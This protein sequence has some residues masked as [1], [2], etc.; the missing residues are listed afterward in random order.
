MNM[1]TKENSA[2]RQK[3]MQQLDHVFAD[4]A[5]NNTNCLV[6]DVAG[7]RRRSGQ[8]DYYTRQFIKKLIAS[9]VL[10]ERQSGTFVPAAQ[11]ERGREKREAAKIAAVRAKGGVIMGDLRLP[12]TEA[13][14][15]RH[16]QLLAESGG[17]HRNRRT[18]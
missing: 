15:A 4:M 10:R 13:L 8:S 12:R 14:A 3:A 18:R 1:T 7:L 6:F 9:G 17:C 2:A 11:E 5:R 16:A